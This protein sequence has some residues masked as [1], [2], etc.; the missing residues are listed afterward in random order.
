[1]RQRTAEWGLA[2]LAAGLLAAWSGVAGAGVGGGA[3]C[4]PDSTCAELSEDDC[5]AEGGVFQPTGSCSGVRCGAC[6]SGID[7]CEPQFEANCISP[8]VFGGEGTTCDGNRCPLCC[9][10]TGESACARPCASEPLACLGCESPCVNTLVFFGNCDDGCEPTGCC[11]T[12]AACVQTDELTCQLEGGIFAPGGS[13]LPDGT[14]TGLPEDLCCRCSGPGEA[15]SQPCRQIN[16]LDVGSCAAMCPPDECVL[17]ITAEGT[18]DDGCRAPGCCEATTGMQQGCLEVDADLCDSVGGAFH[19]GQSCDPQS[20]QCGFFTATPTSTPTV[21]PT[22]TPTST[23]VP[24]GGSCDD[25]SQCEPG[26]ACIGNVCLPPVA[27]VPTVAGSALLA[28][29]AG[30]IAVAGIALWRRRSPSRR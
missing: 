4:L 13:C 29:V 22:T 6:C 28:A 9:S 7:D 5:D 18:C 15:C 1:M 3:C 8:A 30:L 26:L 21:T 11:A 10:C 12:L 27:P 20:G 17:S 2:M 16:V 23:P 24:E 19:E 14:C 25:A